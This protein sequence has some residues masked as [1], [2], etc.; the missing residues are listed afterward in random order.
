MTDETPA[1]PLPKLLADIDQALVMLKERARYERG[2]FEA[3]VDA[4]FT[5][6]QAL[7]LTAQ[8]LRLPPSLPDD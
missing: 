2:A 7:Y 4:G 5:D 3:Y 8:I 1:D 6:A